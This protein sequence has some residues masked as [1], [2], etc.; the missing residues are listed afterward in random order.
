MSNVGVDYMYW[1]HDSHVTYMCQ[2]MY[3]RVPQLLGQRGYWL[4]ELVPTSIH[5]YESQ[6]YLDSVQ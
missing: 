4:S 3:T 1:S 2:Q 6:Y 5:M